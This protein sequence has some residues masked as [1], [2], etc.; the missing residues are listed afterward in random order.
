MLEVDTIE[1]RLPSGEVAYPM[2][3][4]P[5]TWNWDSTQ[6][7]SGS[8]GI[9]AIVTDKSGKTASAKIQLNV[10]NAAT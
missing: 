4:L 6:V 1:I 7:S 5:Y 10:Q 8:Y 3:K 2:K 9:E